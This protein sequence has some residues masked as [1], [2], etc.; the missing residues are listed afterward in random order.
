[1]L[2]YSSGTMRGEITVAALAAIM[3][4]SFVS[5]PMPN[6]GIGQN[7]NAVEVS[8][9]NSYQDIHELSTQ[10]GFIAAGEMDRVIV[11]EVTADFGTTRPCDARRSQL[12]RWTRNMMLS[13]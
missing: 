3:I 2:S 4:L 13:S 10:V 11:S 7:Q 12:W 9:A 1:M 8:W 5:Y 6:D